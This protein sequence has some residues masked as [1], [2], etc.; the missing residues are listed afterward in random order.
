MMRFTQFTY[1]WAHRAALALFWLFC[2]AIAFG[3]IVGLTH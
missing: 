3:L 2:A 1:R